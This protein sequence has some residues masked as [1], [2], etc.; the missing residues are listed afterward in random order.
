MNERAATNICARK[1]SRR[2]AS[3][4]ARQPRKQP[5]K[6]MPSPPASAYAFVIYSDRFTLT[7]PSTHTHTT[8]Q[9]CSLNT[10]LLLMRGRVLL[11]LRFCSSLPLAQ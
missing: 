3:K 6:M 9:A 7:T 11:A 4:P 1:E 10:A 2:H 8:P 5:S